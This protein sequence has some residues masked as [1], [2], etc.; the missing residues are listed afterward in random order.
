MFYF[1]FFL[2]VCVFYFG[3]VFIV[4]YFYVKKTPFISPDYTFITADTLLN[5]LSSL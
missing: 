4:V 1:Y 5:S 2:F 3:L